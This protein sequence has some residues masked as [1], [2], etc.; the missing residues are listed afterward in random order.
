FGI[1]SLHSNY[2]CKAS[3]SGTPNITED[4]EEDN[5]PETQPPPR[6]RQSR[7]PANLGGFFAEP[8]LART[9]I[10]LLPGQL[11]M[12][13]LETIS[14][15][16][17]GQARLTSEQAQVIGR[18]AQYIAGMWGSNPAPLSIRLV[19][20]IDEN[21]WDGQLGAQRAVAVQ[22]EL[23]RAIGALNPGLA[24]RIQFTPTNCGFSTGGRR[25]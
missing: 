18:L 17:P 15:F 9:R 24:A 2:T 10:S 13:P 21:E 22:V 3:H 12:P 23:G 7:A 25:V 1:F 20:Y 8:P 16:A 4:Y 11:R 5:E 19:G 6:R 14:G